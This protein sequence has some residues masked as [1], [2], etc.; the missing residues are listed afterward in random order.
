MIPVLDNVKKIPSNDMINKL[1]LRVTKKYPI[2]KSKK[3]AK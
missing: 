1:I 2:K 3:A